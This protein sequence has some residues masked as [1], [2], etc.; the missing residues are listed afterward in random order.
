[1]NITKNEMFLLGLLHKERGLKYEMTVA[2]QS[3]IIKIINLQIE[4]LNCRMMNGEQMDDDGI[5][6]PKAI[7]DLR[8]TAN[9]L[10]QLAER[11]WQKFRRKKI[12][13]ARCFDKAK[14]I[15]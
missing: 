15:V 11:Y 6:I 1:M 12:C 7:A 10:S 3:S 2:N 4:L 14:N 5:S 8:E 9:S 13:A